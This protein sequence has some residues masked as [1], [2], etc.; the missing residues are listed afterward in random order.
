[1]LRDE[2]GFGVRELSKWAQANMLK[3][4]KELEDEK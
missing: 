2:L 1:V 3:D 4:I